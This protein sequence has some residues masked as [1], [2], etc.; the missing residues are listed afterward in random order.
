M[1][2]RFIGNYFLYRYRDSDFITRQTA[3]VFLTITIFATAIVISLYSYYLFLNLSFSN[4]VMRALALAGCL[5]VL[6]MIRKGYFRLAGNLFLSLFLISIW[7]VMF[8]EDVD[9]L[10]KTDTIALAIAVFSSCSLVLNKNRRMTIVYCLV[11]TAI[12]GA[13]CFYLISA[14]NLSSDAALEYFSDNLI[15]LSL[16]T[17]IAYQVITINAKALD[18]ANESIQSAELEVLKNKRLT[19]TLE[20]KVLERTDE[21]S[22]NNIELQREILERKRVENRLRRAQQELVEN[23]HKAGMAEVAS[24]TLHNVGNTLNSIKTSAHIIKDNLVRSPKEKFSQAC[25]ILREHQDD[26]DNFITKNPK[27]KAIL[28]YFL[29][30]DEEFIKVFDK[31]GSNT[32]RLNDKVDVIA[33]VILSQQR[34]AGT[35]SPKVSA[36]L[37]D[38]LDD[39][40][41]IIPE[42][43][44]NLNIQVTKDF[45][46]VP[47]IKLQKTKILYTFVNLFKNAIQAMSECDPESRILSIKVSGNST[48]VMVEISDTG[49]GITPE[50]LKKIF[51]HGFTTK[52]DGYGF[53]LHS[54]ANCLTEMGASIE[55]QSEGTDK[56]STFILTFPV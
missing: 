1:I 51:N 11:N 48:K 47:I 45:Q 35:S 3:R 15:A 49:S 24:D 33:N 16:I 44:D 22:R 34:Y 8:T 21:L 29:K 50:N 54:C 55:A 30:L 37:T 2:P 19:E 26:L 25:D 12:L 46:S 7:W 43:I 27:G 13:F 42:A 32:K 40:L 38:M 41:A 9:L 4:L 18:R 28:K 56:G 23:A 36:S 39:A 53:G 52:K 10:M 5:I 17:F 31:I 20:Q 14:Y 6:V